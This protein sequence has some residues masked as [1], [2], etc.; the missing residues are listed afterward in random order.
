MFT[1]CYKPE[2]SLTPTL[3]RLSRFQHATT[4]LI[5]LDRFEQR[6]EVSLPE[7]FVA[8]ALDKLKKHWPHQGFRENLQQQAGGGVINRMPKAFSAS[9]VHNRSS[10]RKATC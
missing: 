9:Q 3:G 4:Y 2:R 6:F 8:F 5:T 1:S 10:V 7:T